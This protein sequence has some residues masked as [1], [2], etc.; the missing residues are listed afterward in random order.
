MHDDANKYPVHEISSH[1]SIAAEAT[2]PS[3]ISRLS[4]PGPDSVP[5]VW[6]A[7]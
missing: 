1:S 5:V 4:A 2:E 3:M 7:A 6:L